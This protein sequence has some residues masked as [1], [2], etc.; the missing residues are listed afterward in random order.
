MTDIQKINADSFTKRRTRQAD[1]DEA[2]LA[3]VKMQSAENTQNLYRRALAYFG[4]RPE[5]PD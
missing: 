2:L 5:I 4:I 1:L 3:W